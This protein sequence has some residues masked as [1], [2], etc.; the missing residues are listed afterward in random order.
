M[1]NDPRVEAIRADRVV[2]RGSCSSIDECYDDKDLV[3]A[4]DA[5]GVE[6]LCVSVQWARK[7]DGSFWERGLDQRW[8]EDDDEQLK[9]VRDF[10]ASD[11]Q[12]AVACAEPG[13]V[14]GVGCPCGCHAPD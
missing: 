7:V 10:E 6:A 11:K 14:A 13:C 9:F 4:L 5:A 1:P 3:E 2:G 12:N 8:G